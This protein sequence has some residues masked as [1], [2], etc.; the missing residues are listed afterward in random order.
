MKKN[1]FNKV[2]SCLIVSIILLGIN[3]IVHAS[4]NFLSVGDLIE[5]S[6]CIFIG[7]VLGRAGSTNDI[8]PGIGWEVQIDYYLKGE[9]REQIIIVITPPSNSSVH[10]NLNQW[11]KRVLVFAEKNGE[12]YAPLSP[13]GVMP[14][15][16]DE[17]ISKSKSTLS[18]QELLQNINFI[19]PK[20]DLQ[21]NTKLKEFIKSTDVFLP[22]KIQSQSTNNSLV[23]LC[24]IIG[25]GL[26]IVLFK[27]RKNKKGKIA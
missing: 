18:G 25:L 19:D 8:I 11:G 6:D 9:E 7:E 4:W 2:L 3:H 17:N 23:Y 1:K 22:A 27:I 20:S 16:L 5:Q 21:Y 15:T 12:Y 26:F 24:F 13:Q 10:Y 14:I